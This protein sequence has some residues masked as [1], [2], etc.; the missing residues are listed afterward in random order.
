MLP[1]LTNEE[2]KDK[3]RHYFF[4]DYVESHYQL[5]LGPAPDCLHGYLGTGAQSSKCTV[6]SV[7]QSLMFQG[8]DIS[9]S[10][11]CGAI[12]KWLTKYAEQPTTLGLTLTTVPSATPA[13]RIKAAI[14]C[15]A[16]SVNMTS[17]GY[18]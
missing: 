17:A 2:L 7:N 4:R 6:Q 10:T 3:Y 15:T 14:A 8:T 5:Q 1:L 9:R 12:Q 16:P 11:D 18:V 13:L